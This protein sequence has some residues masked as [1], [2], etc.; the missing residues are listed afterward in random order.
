[1]NKKPS[2]VAHNRPQ[3]FVSQYCPA[4]QTRPELIFYI[5]NTYVPRL[6]CHLICGCILLAPVL[7]GFEN[8]FL[9]WIFFRLHKSRFL[10]LYIIATYSHF[11][12]LSLQ[13]Q[14]SVMRVG[15]DTFGDP[16][17]QSGLQN[18]PS[19]RI[20]FAQL[21]QLGAKCENWTFKVNF[22]CQKSSKSF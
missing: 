6:I 8:I 7:V 13:V 19:S 18:Q 17:F 10:F 14:V 12:S 5:I 2:K 1:M 3:T 15:S 22:L 4:A 11:S 20:C 9:F 21:C 16:I